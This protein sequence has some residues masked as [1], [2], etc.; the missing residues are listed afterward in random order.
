MKEVP[1]TYDANVEWSR[2][3]L[4][5]AMRKER[6]PELRTITGSVSPWGP[7]GGPSSSTYMFPALTSMSSGPSTDQSH[8]IAPSI[9]PASHAGPEPPKQQSFC[10]TDADPEERQKIFSR[11][12]EDAGLD[13]TRESAGGK[14]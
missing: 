5:K 4:K 9:A 12:V 2:E 6:V 8:A 7:L 13:G 10:G 14:L 3:F 1:E 11:M